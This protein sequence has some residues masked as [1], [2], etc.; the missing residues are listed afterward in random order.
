ME[1][2]PAMS[3]SKDV[4]DVL[5]IPDIQGQMRALDNLWTENGYR[6]IKEKK[7]RVGLTDLNQSFARMIESDD[8]FSVNA[9]DK[10]M[11]LKTITGAV[12][13]VV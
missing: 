6:M 9:V 5:S 11:F 8:F 2:M 3:T 10:P 7:I 1:S 4:A 12:E 13:K